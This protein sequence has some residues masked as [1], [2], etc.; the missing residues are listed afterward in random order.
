MR[1]SGA[2]DALGAGDKA[3]LEASFQNALEGGGSHSSPLC[4]F[5][6]ARYGYEALLRTTEP[7]LS[8]P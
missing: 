8:I 4:R 6:R 7:S 5:E 2:P 3:G 1:L